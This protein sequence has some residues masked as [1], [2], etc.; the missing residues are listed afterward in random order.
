MLA[1]KGLPAERDPYGD[2]QRSSGLA[3][4]ASPTHHPRTQSG[5]VTKTRMSIF[6]IGSPHAGR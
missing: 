6:G 4:I 1:M 2:R 5:V 3:L